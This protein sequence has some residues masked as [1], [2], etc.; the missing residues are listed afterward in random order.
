LVGSVPVVDRATR[1]APLTGVFGVDEQHGDAGMSGLG[2]DECL[3]LE[4]IA[5]ALAPHGLGLEASFEGADRHDAVGLETD[6]SLVARLGRALMEQR[7]LGTGFIGVGDLGPIAQLV[8]VELPNGHPL[9]GSRSEPMRSVIHPLE[10]AAQDVHFLG[11]RREF[12]V[13]DPLRG[14]RCSSSVEQKRGVAFLCRLNA[15]V[16]G[17]GFP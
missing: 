11:G 14:P 9:E 4:Q 1:G 17:G 15:T 13:D 12:D 8:Q 7:V 2:R 3:Q 6:N 10:G 16:S 5:P